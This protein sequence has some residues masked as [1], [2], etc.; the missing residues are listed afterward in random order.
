MSPAPRVPAVRATPAAR[1]ISIAL[2]PV[3]RVAVKTPCA[4]LKARLPPKATEFGTRLHVYS[5]AVFRKIA[6]SGI[7]H[8]ADH[9][10]RSIRTI[11]ALG[12]CGGDRTA[13]GSVG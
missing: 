7:R 11:Y 12:R 5:P 9:G 8:A 10:R 6:R 1:V 4:C 3:R 13:M 2:P